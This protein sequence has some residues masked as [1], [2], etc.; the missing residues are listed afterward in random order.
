[1]KA[2]RPDISVDYCYRRHG[3]CSE[4]YIGEEDMYGSEG[5]ELVKNMLNFGSEIA[6]ELIKKHKDM[7]RSE[8]F[9]M[10]L[11]VYVDQYV[12]L[13]LD[14]MASLINESWLYLEWLIFRVLPL[15]NRK[16]S[17]KRDS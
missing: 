3:V 8:K 15:H 1:M 4:E 11:E 16:I 13:F 14:Q 10:P 6:L 9:R 5:W 2:S 7:G 17:I 12:H